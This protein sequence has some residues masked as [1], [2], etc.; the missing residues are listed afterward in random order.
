MTIHASTREEGC[1]VAGM[2]ACLTGPIGPELATKEIARA[3]VN[4]VR[5]RELDVAT[6]L[7]VVTANQWDL[8]ELLERV[9]GDRQ[10]MRELLLIFRVDSRRTMQKAKAAIGEGDW[11]G[12]SRAAHTLAGMLKN[13]AM[14]EAA[15]LAEELETTARKASPGESEELLGKLEDSLAEILPRVEAQLVEVQ[16]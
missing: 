16:I 5:K 3:S 14:G 7:P 1:C 15:K 13:L 10:F 11:P 12:L 8:A 9:E 6:I 2:N 4:D